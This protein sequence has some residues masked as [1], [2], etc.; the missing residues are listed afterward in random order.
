MKQLHKDILTIGRGAE[1]VVRGNSSIIIISAGRMI[2]L[3]TSLSSESP[4]SVLLRESGQH[5]TSIFT[6]TSAQAMELYLDL[7]EQLTRKPRASLF[8]FVKSLSVTAAAIAI[9]AA[10]SIGLY[11]ARHQAINIDTNDAAEALP[12]NP[13]ELS[14]LDAVPSS[15]K[16]LKRPDFL[17]AGSHLEAIAG[18][19]VGNEEERQPNEASG[20]IT[21][22]EF[23]TYKPTLYDNGN[24]QIAPVTTPKDGTKIPAGQEQNSGSAE[25]EKT[26]TGKETQTDSVQ[27]DN[28]KDAA[29]T[30]QPQ[31]DDSGD[32]EGQDAE[33][34]DSMIEKNA[35]AAIKKL[36]SNGMP[37]D[38]VRKLLMTLQQLNVGG[39]D[40]VT[41]EMLQSLPEEIAALLAD[42]GMDLDGPGG[43]TMNILPSEIVDRYRGKDGI[44]SIPENY[45][46]YARTGGTVY[47]PLPGGGDIAKPEDFNDFGLAP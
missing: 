39:A 34:H 47:L 33:A 11:E 12:F 42:Q 22:F 13:D 21:T 43:G 29:P 4:S 24:D 31:K 26:D 9:V 35:D 28:K 1:F 15:M 19:A 45:S 38:E 23:P 18:A 14:S 20:A 8:S 44:A 30:P 3:T 10:I 27:G 17:N 36:I 6:G 25:P 40:G 16:V 5:E 41:P 46:W 37:Q 7:E 2:E 32:K